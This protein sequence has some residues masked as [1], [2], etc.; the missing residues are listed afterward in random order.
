MRYEAHSMIRVTQISKDYLQGKYLFNQIK[1]IF[2]RFEKWC[3]FGIRA[4]EKKAN[5]SD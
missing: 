3:S 2:K 5:Q 4:Y 1:T